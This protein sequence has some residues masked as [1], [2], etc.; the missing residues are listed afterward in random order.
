MSEVLSVGMGARGEDADEGSLVLVLRLQARPSVWGVGLTT[1]DGVEVRPPWARG[2]RSARA[3][4]S[5]REIRE[6]NEGWI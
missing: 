4:V 5:Q 1:S 3:D 6:R 2:G